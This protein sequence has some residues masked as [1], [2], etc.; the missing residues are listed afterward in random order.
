[1]DYYI[2]PHIIDKANNKQNKETQYEAGTKS[3]TEFTIDK[4]A[5]VISMAYSAE[6]ETI[7]PGGNEVSR[8]Y[9]NKTITATAT[10][11]ERNF[12]NSNSFSE[13]PKQMNLTYEALN[14][15]GSK[16]N[17]ENY[18]GTANTRGEWST[19]VYTRTKT[20][21]FSQDANYTLGLVYR[22]LAGNEAVYDTRYFTVD[23]TAPT[24]SMTHRG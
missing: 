18:T 7:N 11:E 8:V 2:V 17:T 10:I 16:V 19:N 3:K 5:P 21:T 15:Q 6:G 1:M 22:D 12:S 4:K 20:F 13:D 9:R 23:K 24:G 14:F